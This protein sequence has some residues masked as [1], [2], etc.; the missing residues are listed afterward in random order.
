MAKAATK[1][2]TKAAALA[3][4]MRFSRYG[5]LAQ[6]FI[7]DALGK[8]YKPEPKHR[9]RE[10]NEKLVARLIK[11]DEM[12]DSTDALDTVTNYANA[13]ASAGLE[14]VRASFAKA[15]GSMVH[16]DSWYGVAVEI[17]DK[18]AAAQ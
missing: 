18:L 14:G 13:V 3:E 6:L 2:P 10:D 16:P 8:G 7:L 5:A 15:G 12:R 17:R 11:A 9:P 4:L 1:T